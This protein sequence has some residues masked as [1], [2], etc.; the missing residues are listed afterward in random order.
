[1]EVRP[2]VTGQEDRGQTLVTRGLNSGE[3]VV[4]D[5]Q[6]RLQPGAAVQATDEKTADA[7]PA[8]GAIAQ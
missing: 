8:G 1:V 5:G 3:R 2:V 7:Q 4:L 6:L